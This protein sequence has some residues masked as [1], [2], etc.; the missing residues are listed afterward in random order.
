MCFMGTSGLLD[1]GTTANFQS[2]IDHLPLDV[3]LALRQVVR[4]GSCQLNFFQLYVVTPHFPEVSAQKHFS[5]VITMCDLHIE[6][7]RK[8][9][10]HNAEK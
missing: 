9:I 8:M 5:R 3:D 2:N 6:K 7:H 10:A 4:E 1:E